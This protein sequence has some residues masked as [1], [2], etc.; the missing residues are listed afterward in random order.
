MKKSIFD[1]IIIILVFCISQFVGSLVGVIAWI[2]YHFKE[3]I[4]LA[5]ETQDKDEISAKIMNAVIHSPSFLGIALIAGSF[6]SIFFLV[7]VKKI[8]L[9]SEF[10][11]GHSKLK[12][13]PF[14]FVMVLLI[15]VGVNII[16]EQTEIENTLDMSLT[17]MSYNVWG[18]LACCII[19]PIAE[20]LIFRG[21]M[22]GGMLRRGVKPWAAILVSAAIF[23]LIHMN[24]AQIPAAFCLGILFGIVYYRTHSI[25]PACLLHIFNNSFAT[26]L[27]VVMGDDDAAIS[28]ALG[29][30]VSTYVMFIGLLIGTVMVNH[31][32][33]KHE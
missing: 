1:I 15:I 21:A 27:T 16:V 14:V 10:S 28:D 13:A 33:T 22:C 20:E 24:P 18:V 29:S 19:G 17:A 2:V 30:S 4:P 3:L 6:L 26:V 11:I 32:C 31:Y 23:G 9:K 5:L 7:L 25:I 8:S 12:W